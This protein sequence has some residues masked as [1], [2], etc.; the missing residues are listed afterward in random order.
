MR[1]HLTR[2]GGQVDEFGFAPVGDYLRGDG[3][4]H[5][6][7]SF[8]VEVTA[9]YGSN[10]FDWDYESHEGRTTIPDQIAAESG[11]GFCDGRAGGRGRHG[12]TDRYRAGRAVGNFRSGAHVFRAWL[13][14]FT[15]MPVTR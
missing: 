7:H 11:V 12:R 14:K 6:P 3:I 2:L 13:Q 5:E 15:G 9:L 1:I 4:V 8:D 10:E